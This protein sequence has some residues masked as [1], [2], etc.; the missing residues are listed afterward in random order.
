MYRFG[1]ITEEGKR[2]NMGRCRYWV[3]ALC[4]F[5][6]PVR[7]G[8]STS[9]EQRTT[10]NSAGNCACFIFINTNMLTW[11]AATSALRIASSIGFFFSSGQSRCRPSLL[12]QG[13]GR[14]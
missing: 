10:G 3:C 8:I 7:Y 11:V 1:R 9:G 5:Y 6:A 14:G 13:C 12:C 2:S 4:S